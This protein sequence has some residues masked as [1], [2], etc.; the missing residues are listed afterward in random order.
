MADIML[1]TMPTDDLL[2][3]KI[4]VELVRSGHIHRG[5]E[6]GIPKKA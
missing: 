4:R 6:S 1:V 5:R 3:L 2:Q